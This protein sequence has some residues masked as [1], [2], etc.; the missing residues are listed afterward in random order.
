M[1]LSKKAIW[2]VMGVAIIVLI[3]VLVVVLGGSSTEPTPTPTPTPAVTGEPTEQAVYFEQSSYTVSGGEQFVT[4]VNITFPVDYFYGAQFE[5]DWDHTLLSLRK[6]ASMSEGKGKLWDGSSWHDATNFGMSLN[7][8]GPDGQGH[9]IVLVDWDAYTVMTVGD[10]ISAT[11]GWL[12]DLYWEA[13]ASNTGTTEVQFQ[14]TLELAG[15]S[16][17]DIDFVIP[18]VW[19]DTSITVQ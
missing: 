3:V 19:T 12:C 8:P 16:I 10:G 13:D 2:V 6:S 18:A 15:L 14:E 17:K 7:G 1:K 5:L 9:A 4:R 11:E